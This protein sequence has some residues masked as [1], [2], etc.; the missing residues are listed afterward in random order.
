[1]NKR[2]LPG[3]HRDALHLNTRKVRRVGQRAQTVGLVRAP[4]RPLEV[5][6]RRGGHYVR[7]LAARGLVGL[8][9]RL[10]QMVAHAYRGGYLDLRQ[11]ECC[12]CLSRRLRRHACH[13]IGASAGHALPAR[14]PLEFEG[15]CRP[16]V[17]GCNIHV[18]LLDVASQI[19]HS[20]AKLAILPSRIHSSI[21]EPLAL[22]HP[23]G[24]KVVRLIGCIPR[25]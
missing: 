5:N 17:S 7:L 11:V 12:V 15:A 1:M 23:G 20:R 13:L 9:A 16:E 24:L 25:R 22:S 19:G 8:G 6:L 21:D 10:L 3:I 14:A 4:R 18:I 2:S